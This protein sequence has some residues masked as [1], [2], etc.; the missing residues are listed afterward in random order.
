[1]KRLVTILVLALAMPTIASADIAVTLWAGPVLN[2]ANFNWTYTATLKSGATLN[3]GDF[4]TIYDIGGFGPAVPIAG[5]VILPAAGWT[6]SIQ[7]VGTNG[8]G[9]APADNVGIYNVTFTRTGAAIVAASDTILGGIGGFGYTSSNATSFTGAYSATTHVTSGGATAGNSSTVTVAGS[10]APILQSVVSRRVHGAAGTFNLPLSFANIH[11]PTTEPRQGPAQTVVFTF[12]QPITGAAV[13]ITEGT[14]TAAV[15]TFSGNDVTVG[16]TNV[17]N[18]QYVT[19]S[20]A[21]VASGANG[22]GSGSIRVGFLAGDVNQNRVVS[23][24]D[25]G[26]VNAQLAQPVTA[27]NYLKDV[28]VTGT[29]TVA[30]K[31]ITNAN[32]TRAL[33]TP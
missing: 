23:V 18:Q 10:L 3:P 8:F 27:A 1:M 20:L 5:N 4:F 17:T 7:L 33:P 29:L 22:G 31:G 19:I 28:N 21:N 24:A 25:L 13:T 2:G 32:L 12:D 14:A 26:L 16:L 15:P 11:N 30:D 9:Q 6:F